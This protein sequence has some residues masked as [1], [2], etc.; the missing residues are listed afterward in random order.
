[1]FKGHFGLTQEALAYNPS[2]NLNHS[3]IESIARASRLP[4]VLY[5]TD[6]RYHAQSQSYDKDK[7]YVPVNPEADKATFQKLFCEKINSAQEAIKN[8]FLQDFCYHLGF[9]LHMIQDL[10]CHQGMTNPEHACLDRQKG[11]KGESLSPDLSQPSYDLAR[12]ASSWVIEHHFANSIREKAGKLK[13]LSANSKITWSKFDKVK[14]SLEL[15]SGN[16]E[17]FFLK[18]I[19][20][21][22]YVKD[23]HKSRWFTEDVR[24]LDKSLNQIKTLVGKVI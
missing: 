10:A 9:V 2:L 13:E 14:S 17:F 18:Y 6:L 20:G 7:D 4:D 16:I 1:M 11:R 5:F 22:E 24:Q 15:I 19:N 8:N 12:M 23:E 21:L 3:V